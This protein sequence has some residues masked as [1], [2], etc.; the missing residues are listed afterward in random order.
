MHVTV[1]HKL[2]VRSGSQTLQYETVAIAYHSGRTASTGHF[3][4][5]VKRGTVIYNVNN[6]RITQCNA[7]GHNDVKVSPSLLMLRRVRRN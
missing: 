2:S 3:F 1:L 7:F 5:Q 4:A 6:E